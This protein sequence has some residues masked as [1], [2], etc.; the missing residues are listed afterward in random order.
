M[1][2]ILAIADE[3]DQRLYGE[4]L[5]RLRPDVV[6]SCGDLPFE[7]LENI[8]TRAAVPL[9]YVPGNH[10]PQVGRAPQPGAEWP[11]LASPLDDLP[12]PRGCD[13]ADG[14]LIHAAGLNIAGLGGSLR[15]KQG[16]NQ[17]TQREMRW[18]ALQL[19]ARVRLRWWRRLDA[20]VAHAPPLG[21][22]DGEDMVH[23]GFAAFHRLVLQLKPRVLLH[24]HVHPVHRRAADRMLGQTLIVNAIPYRL[25]EV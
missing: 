7:Y 8:V 2:R 12:G 3:V 16:P 20:I 14:R 21:V 25:L 5:Q 22:G 18:R 6:V 11:L 9:I 23:H 19:E 13:N 15:Y 10:D 17:Y 1:A 24:G 4:A